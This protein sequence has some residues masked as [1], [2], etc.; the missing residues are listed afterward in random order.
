MAVIQRVIFMA[1]IAATLFHVTTAI[2]GEATYYTVYVP[3]A[4]YGFQNQGTMI[5]AVNE[6]LWANGRN[7]GR[8]IRVRCTG[9]TNNGVLQPCRNGE[10]TVRIVDRCPGCHANQIDLSQEAFSM[11]ADTNAGRIRTEYNLV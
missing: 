7:C 3:S 9:R 10:I 5:A 8:S 1:F 11:I 4:C 2:A 6:P